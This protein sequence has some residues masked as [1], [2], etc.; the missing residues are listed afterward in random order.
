MT[1]DNPNDTVNAV[2]PQAVRV[3]PDDQAQAQ[4]VEPASDVFAEAPR[5]GEE[6]Q[7]EIA[8]AD[9]GADD[10]MSDDASEVEEESKD[11]QGHLGDA[12]T[13]DPISTPNAST[14]TQSPTAPS[15]SSDD[16]DERCE[17]E[18]QPYDFDHC[19][20]QIAIQLLPD[21][22]GH[23]G[24]SD[25]NGRM[26]VVGVRS[27]LDTPILRCV[28]L[29]ELGALPPIVNALLDELKAELPT[30][31]QAARAA[32]EKKEIE[33]AKRKSVVTVS[34]TS[35]RGKKTKTPMSAVPASNTMA[36]DNRPRPEV[37]VPANPQQ[38]IGL[39]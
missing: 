30:R 8:R 17:I 28:R 19:T 39:F 33:K 5:V 31:E 10:E 38:Q 29:N 32:F 11:D 37:T 6:M 34:R 36:A 26:V 24:D 35:A 22:Q 25:S 7:D 12:D 15:A 4:S 16:A 21:D 18:R 1:Q 23:L 3:V 27:H 9:D 13:T 14:T 20:V 2:D